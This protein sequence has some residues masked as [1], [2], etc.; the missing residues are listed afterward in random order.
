MNR[1]DDKQIEY[2]RVEPL[3]KA[4][5]TDV[6]AHLLAGPD[7]PTKVF[8]ALN[9]LAAATVFILRGTGD[10]PVAVTFFLRA[11]KDQLQIQDGQDN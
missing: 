9:A 5:L 8:E 6:R 11:F 7:S 3:F 4:I 1:A 2:E 10:D